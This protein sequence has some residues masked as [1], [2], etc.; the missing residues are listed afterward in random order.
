[1]VTVSGPPAATAPGAPLGHNKSFCGGA[2][3][4][5]AVN[6]SVARMACSLTISPRISG[7][8]EHYQMATRGRE[9]QADFFATSPM[10]TWISG[11]QEPQ[12]VPHLRRLP[13]SP[14]VAP[15]PSSRAQ[16][17]MGLRPTPKHEHTSAP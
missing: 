12:L 9:A 17:A 11:T 14:A 15:V 1:M 2:A 3:L 5:A 13:I 10:M 8:A 16:A 7:S 4:A 6:T